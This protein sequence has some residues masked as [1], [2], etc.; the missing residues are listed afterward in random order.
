VEY[1]R[2]VAKEGTE[3]HKPAIAFAV[4]A[5][6][7]S[8]YLI[9]DGL[10]FTSRIEVVS[11]FVTACAFAVTPIRRSI[12]DK[13]S[14]VNKHIQKL[15]LTFLVLVLV[16]KIF[17]FALQ[18]LGSGFETCYRSVYSPSPNNACEKSYEHPFYRNDEVNAIGD[19]TRIDKTINFGSRTETA[20]SLLGAGYSNWNLPFA[21]DYPRLSTPWLS[22]LPFTVQYGGFV[23][24]ER[25]GVIPIEYVGKISLTLGNHN[26]EGES[27]SQRKTA[28]IPVTP[29]RTQFSLKYTFTDDDTAEIPD[30]PPLARGPYAHLFVGAV[31]QQKKSPLATAIQKRGWIADTASARKIVA[32]RA[33]TA[34]TDEL[35]IVNTTERTDVGQALNNPDLSQAGFVIDIP[36][37]TSL[38]EHEQIELSAVFVDGTQQPFATISPGVPGPT[39]IIDSP[40]LVIETDL[41]LQVDDATYTLTERQQALSAGRMATPSTTVVVLMWL[42]D[43][44]QLVL[45]GAALLFGLL[46]IRRPLMN[47]AP[48]LAMSVGAIAVIRFVRQF[49]AIDWTTIQ[50]VMVIALVGLFHARKR[51]GLLVSSLIVGGYLTIG[52]MLAFLQ[53]SMGVSPRS[54][55]GTQLFRQR[56]SDW[57]VYQGYAR[58]IYT[59]ES[60]RGGENIFYFMPGAR[61]LIF[62][63]HLLFGDNDVLIALLTGTLL[64]ALLIFVTVSFCSQIDR[65]RDIIAVVVPTA[66]VLLFTT[67]E[68]VQ[69]AAASAGE[70]PAWIL[71]IVSTLFIN[72]PASEKKHYFWLAASLG[73]AANF[74]PNISV[75][76]VWILVLIVFK[77]VRDLPEHLDA[78]NRSAQVVLVFGGVFCLSLI[79]NLWYGATWVFFKPLQADVVEFP[80]SQL[81]S[82]F[83]DGDMRSLVVNKTL[84]ALRW[85]DIGF[86]QPEAIASLVLQSVWLF[87]I[88]ILLRKPRA[89]WFLL[90]FGMTPVLLLVS[91]LPFLYTSMPSRHFATVSLMFGITALAMLGKSDKV[92]TSRNRNDPGEILMESSVTL[93]G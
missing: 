81:A 61:Y 42:I 7:G 10:P 14:T 79:H 15:A 23:D 53:T 82:V 62:I 4:V 77:I 18:P 75:A 34:Q 88:S 2:R 20:D 56:D 72:I 52:R 51:T 1:V 32:I 58:E 85:R 89:N 48:V 60:L 28:L 37:N 17:T 87:A 24:I 65:H 84:Q 30:N 5:V 16:A 69:F 6:P 13:L 46:H 55:W 66:V 47:A 43:G 11:F 22:R 57:L 80:A 21:N 45:V 33:S 90:L 40:T 74:R 54:W 92:A 9:L 29:G 86:D 38:A 50:T 71:L 12:I 25:S 93:G 31:Q 64:V 67:F 41:L 27:Y 59:S 49:V 39:G 73:V 76:L 35:A 70:V 68:M 36:V 26:Y 19:L 8:P 78:I 63:E 3:W 91:Q 83:W 44:I